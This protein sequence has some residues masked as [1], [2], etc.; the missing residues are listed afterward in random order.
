MSRILLAVAAI[1]AAA[2]M[3]SSATADS[4]KKHGN[5]GVAYKESYRDGP[6]R[7]E[8]KVRRNGDYDEKVKCDGRRG[9]GV[10]YYRPDVVIV[11][12]VRSHDV[13]IPTSGAMMQ[14]NRDLM[15]GLIGAGVG[16]L[17]IGRGNGQLAATAAGT[18]IG[19]LVGGEIGRTMDRVDQACAGQALERL[20]PNQMATWQGANGAMYQVRP[21]SVIDTRLG[22][23]CREFSTTAIIG[24][25]PEEL[26]GTACRQSD[27][28]WKVVS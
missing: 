11:D 7:I 6:C 14:C 25:R 24:G 9:S 4:D 3:S 23:M 19:F 18:V 17:A 10:V 15:G 26:V 22:R 13:L 28:S 16:G 5:R 27:G 21:T 1:A 8:R 20:G 12:P 2:A